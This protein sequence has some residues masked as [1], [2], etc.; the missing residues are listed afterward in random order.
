MTVFEKRIPPDESNSV[1]AT[2][3]HIPAMKGIFD[4]W[5]QIHL[6]FECSRNGN[7]AIECGGRGDNSVER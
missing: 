7:E 2:W 1:R 5:P 3:K 6:S 4:F